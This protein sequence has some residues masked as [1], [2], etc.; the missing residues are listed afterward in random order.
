MSLIVLIKSY[1]ISNLKFSLI[2]YFLIILITT[3]RFRYT[4]ENI[5][6][7]KKYQKNIYKKIICDYK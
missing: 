7:R 6:K 1:K 2:V 3:I 5:Y 4:I